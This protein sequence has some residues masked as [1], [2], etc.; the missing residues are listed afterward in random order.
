MLQLFSDTEFV[1]DS[2]V[3]VDVFL[4]EVAEKV[5]SLTNH[6]EKTA[7][8]MVVL[9]VLFKVLCELC[10]SLCENSDLN[11]GRTCV[12]FVCLVTKVLSMQASLER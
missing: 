10:D 4:L 7:T 12:V 5:S 2:T 3:T 8:A 9:G 6:F 11:F 1:D